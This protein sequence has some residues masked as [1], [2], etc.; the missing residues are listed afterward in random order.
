MV[1]ATDPMKNLSDHSLQYMLPGFNLKDLPSDMQDI[2]WHAINV[3]DRRL[4]KGRI[5]EAAIFSVPSLNVRYH[6][7][8]FNP[9]KGGI[10]TNDLPT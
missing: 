4:D 9:G 7:C 2:V 8:K 1:E 3:K 5:H 6:A 10:L